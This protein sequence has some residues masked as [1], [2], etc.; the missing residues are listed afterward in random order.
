MPFP[1]NGFGKS[2]FVKNVVVCEGGRKNQVIG[3]IWPASDEVGSPCPFRLDLQ[4]RKSSHLPAG[5]F[6]NGLYYN[7]VGLF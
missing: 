5:W 3:C 1:G 2:C 4:G 7:G 6:M